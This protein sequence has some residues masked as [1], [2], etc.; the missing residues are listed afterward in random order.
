MNLLISLCIA[1]GLGFLLVRFTNI[2][3]VSN[4][5]LTIGWVNK[6]VFAFLYIFIFTFYF[7]EGTLIGDSNNFFNNGFIITQLAYDHPWEYIKLMFGFADELSDTILPYTESTNIWY[8]GDNG[9]FINDNR[10]IIRINSLLHLVSFQ[11]IYIHAV[12]FALFSYIGIILI[13]KSFEEFV[14]SKKIFWYVLVICPSVAFWG[15]ALLKESLL[16]FAM[17]LL[18]YSINRL[19]KK[20][21]FKY[22]VVLIVAA[23]VL[24]FNKPYAGLIILPISMFWL[25]GRIL[26]WNIRYLY[27]LS[28]FTV[29]LFVVL[30][31]TPSKINLTEKVSYKQKDLTNLGIGG[32]FFINDSAFCAF[33]YKYLNHFDLVDDSLIVVNESAAGEYKL[34]GKYEFHKFN[35]EPS[36]SQYPHYLTQIPSGSFYEPTLINNSNKQLLLNIPSAIFNVLVRPFPWDNGNSLKVLSFFQNFGLIVLLVFAFVKRKK[37]VAQEKYIITFIIFSIVFITLLIGWTTPIFGAAVRYKVPI[38]VLII[39]L[40]FI[41]LKSTKNEKV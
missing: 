1:I 37:I 6:L 28:L 13:Y 7:G 40:S 18:F 9:D 39:I 24:L 29:G 21:S 22:W 19:I 34:F 27:I 17:G 15:G 36:E 23:L 5:M 2:N 35:I 11:N 30:L 32:V 31:F 8:Y 20:A 10:L 4:K 33:D 25:V 38:D 16:V 26:K 14:E 12:T 3:G 41:L